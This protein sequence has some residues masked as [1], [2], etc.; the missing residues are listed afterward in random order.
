MAMQ[1]FG[2]PVDPETDDDDSKPRVSVER[3]MTLVLAG[4]WLLLDYP[5]GLCAFVAIATVHTA[6]A[7]R[8]PRSVGVI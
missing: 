4:V 1:R 6:R 3:K 8:R 2:S 7:M 5:W